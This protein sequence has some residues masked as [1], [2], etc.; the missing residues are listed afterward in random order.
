M[1]NWSRSRTKKV[2]CR[3]LGDRAGGVMMEYVIL[4]VL[5]AAAV[6]VAVA[7]FGKTLVGMFDVAAKGATADHSGAKS[8]QTQ[9]QSEQKSKATQAKQYHDSMHK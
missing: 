2:L 6:V 7:M 4:A 1:K 8:A 5:I 9:T 3:L